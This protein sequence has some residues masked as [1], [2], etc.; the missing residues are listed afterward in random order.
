MSEGDAVHPGFLGNSGP[1]ILHSLVVCP[2]A[3]S[4]HSKSWALLSGKGGL[5]EAWIRVS[6]TTSPTTWSTAFR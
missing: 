1:W 2:R 3:P 6:T 4:T 5:R